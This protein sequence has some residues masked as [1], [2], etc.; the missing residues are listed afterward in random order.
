MRGL[1]VESERRLCKFLVVRLPQHKASC[2]YHARF[3]KCLTNGVGFLF[4]N[5]VS[6]FDAST[7]SAD[8]DWRKHSRQ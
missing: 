7:T 3:Y 1:M 4:S 6:D 8:D 5:H 2:F